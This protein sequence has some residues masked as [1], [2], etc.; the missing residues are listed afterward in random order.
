MYTLILKTKSFY[1]SFNVYFIF[2]R[3]E[4]REWGKVREGDTVSKAG[5][6]LRAVSTEPSAGLEPTHCAILAW[7]EIGCLTN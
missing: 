4:E 7:A 1:S 6:R 5:S 2:E 3:E